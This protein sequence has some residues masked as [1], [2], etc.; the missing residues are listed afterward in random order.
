MNASDHTSTITDYFRTNYTKCP[1]STF[2][3]SPTFHTWSCHII[4]LFT[5]PMN[6]YATYLIIVK[7]PRKLQQMKYCLLHLHS[8]CFFTDL[9]SGVFVVP[10]TLVPL[11][12]GHG[13]GLL[14]DLNVPQ[15][16][17]IYT[18]VVAVAGVGFA[19]AFMFE[20]RQNSMI[21]ESWFRIQNKS[22]RFLFYTLN[23]AF[24]ISFPIPAFLDVPDQETAKMELLQ[25]IPCPTI[26]FFSDKVFVLIVQQTMSFK[27]VSAAL[28]LAFVQILFF[29]IHSFWCLSN[30][31]KNSRVSEK[32]RK[33]QRKFLLAVSIQVIIPLA[34][35]VLP[36]V[37]FTFS[38]F[39]Q[40]HSQALNNICFMIMSLHGFLDSIVMIYVITPYREYTKT[41]LFRTY[42][43]RQSIISVV[44]AES[45]RYTF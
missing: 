27:L 25:L 41:V 44:G 42:Q 11:C 35:C 45:T 6:V 33:L 1:K 39:K 34:V 12:A 24:M 32:T 15:P 40:F 28:F 38:M 14:S 36:V 43:K 16:F 19:I 20:N 22:S 37:Y 21:S 13:A 29:A 18:F 10:Y 23:Y 7:T 30:T 31:M 8:W 2:F 3:D 17:Q 4:S 26:H 9:L 5:L